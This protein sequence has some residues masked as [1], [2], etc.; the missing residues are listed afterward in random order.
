MSVSALCIGHAAYDLCMVV[1]AYPPENSKTETDLL[2]ESGGGPA[3]N[4]AWVLARWGVATA[5]AARV[6][7]DQYG[8]RALSELHQAGVDCRLMKGRKARETPVSFITVNRG[9]GSRTII[10]RKPPTPPLKLSARQ[11]RGLNPKL[12]LFDG[13]ELEASL[14]AM[15]AFPSAITLL[16]AGSLR[17]GTRT[18]AGRVEYLVCSER[19]ARQV[20]RIQNVSHSWARCLRRLRQLNGRVVVVTLGDRGLIYDDGRRRGRLPA[21]RVKT[22]DTTGAGD[23]FHGALGYALLRGM[24]LEDALRWAALAAALSVRTF[25]GRPSFPELAAVEEAFRHG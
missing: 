19:F 8:R 5:L 23:L 7:T 20:T 21:T 15:K 11:L 1:N 24:E 17:E 6:G 16:D 18:L 4:A 13:H 2:I 12:L 10:N 22:V 14:A 3:A 25:G 9:N